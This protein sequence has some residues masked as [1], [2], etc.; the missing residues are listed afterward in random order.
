MNIIFHKYQ[1]TGN[2]FIMINGLKNSDALTLSQENIEYLC[3][4]RFGIGADGLIILCPSE[5][6]DYKMLY[7][8]SDGRESTMCGNGG[9]CLAKFAFDQ[10]VS[11]REASFEAVD[12]M[13]R[14]T[15]L[16]SG[17][18]ELE[19]IDVDTF[20]SLTEDTF[21]I[22]TGSPHYV[23]FSSEFDNIDIVKFGKSIRYSDVYND[24]GI[25]V[26]VSSFED[27]LLHVKTYERG[28]EDETYSCGTGVTAAAICA[29]EYFDNAQNSFD[30]QSKGG[31]LKV[32]FKKDGSRFTDIW[33]SGPATFVFEG[34][35][36]I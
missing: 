19:M 6:V 2:D 9:R 24:D 28:V 20:T 22:N 12:G 23:K 5:K 13:H 17:L 16:E 21:E 36:K 1:G 31:N 11:D 7:F 29:S 4:R 30:I 33:L 32:R 10:G 14:S 8:N 35:F 34:E 27:G 25:N 26:N 3:S 15:V 18:V